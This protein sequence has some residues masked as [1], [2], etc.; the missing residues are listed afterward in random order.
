MKDKDKTLKHLQELLDRVPGVRAAGRDSPEFQLWR[1]ESEVVVR[2]AFGEDSQQLITFK[3]VNY[4]PTIAWDESDFRDAFARGLVVAEGKLRAMIME[5]TEYGPSQPSDEAAKL[6]VSSDTSNRKVFVIHGH[7]G[8][9][10]HELA[11]F[12]KQLDLGPVILSEQPSK[13]K[14]I[15]EKFDEC[16]AVSYAVALLTADDVGS[17]RHESAAKPRARQNVI[18][19]LGY[20]IG[21]LGRDRV[22]ALT[23]GE[24]EIPTNYSGVVYI[25]MDSGEWKIALAKE[26]D[27]ADFEIDMNKLK[28]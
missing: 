28:Q 6:A 27:G 23:K 19:E 24:P 12:L 22:C 2:H 7:D 5:V 17:R 8:A 1:E 18:F 25:P 16:A 26:L 15:I 21:R 4:S 10:K 9:A 11:R 13:G 3:N 20:F 14:T